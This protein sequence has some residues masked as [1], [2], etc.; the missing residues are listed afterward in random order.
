M[1]TTMHHINII[2]S[3]L[4]SP[5]LVKC[6]HTQNVCVRS[7]KI[8]LRASKV[9]VFAK[10]PHKMAEYTEACL[11]C[12]RDL[13]FK[14]PLESHFSFNKKCFVGRAV[15]IQCALHLFNLGECFTCSQRVRATHRKFSTGF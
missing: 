9:K 8:F 10:N 14:N 6:L 12:F 7:M 2:R 15:L 13:N 4:H 3:A 5:D 1:F 11:S